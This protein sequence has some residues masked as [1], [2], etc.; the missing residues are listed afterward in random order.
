MKE[1]FRLLKQGSMSSL[2][3]SIINAVV[4]ITKG[5]VFFITG[6]VAMFAELMHSIGDTV[7]QAFVYIG[8]ALSN[9]PPTDRFPEGFARLVNLVLLGAVLIVGVLA[10]E[11]IKKGINR[12]IAP[13]ESN[14]WLWLNVSVLGIAMILEG[15]VWFKSMKEIT[16][17]LGG[18]DIKGFNI[19]SESFKNVG[20]ANP[21]T[22]LVFL[23]DAVATSGAFI[24]IIAIFIGAY[25]PF[26]SAEGY[27]SVVIGLMLFLVVGRIF[28][29]NAA[30]ALGAA[31]Q[32]MVKKVGEYV[33]EEPKVK[34]IR[35]L[36]VMQEGNELHAELKIELESDMTIAEADQI[37]DNIEKKILDE[38]RITDVIIE[39]DDHDDTQHWDESKNETKNS[40][41]G[42]GDGQSKQ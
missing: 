36:A 4:A 24:A 11:T 3:A 33:Y 21:A 17:D 22:K 16:A 41:K 40:E 15:F 39:F 6:N 23:E 29:D 25:T 18:E 7:N 19:I 34:D 31:D 28:L 30:G 20:K 12:I 32:D 1:L 8:S 35:K 14:E 26:Q 9:K 10:Y 42:S 5:V 27:A 38:K 13:P 2:W 37:H